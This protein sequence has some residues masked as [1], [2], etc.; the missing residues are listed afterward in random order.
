MYEGQ[1]YLVCIMIF[2]PKLNYSVK[3]ATAIERN[4]LHGHGDQHDHFGF[5]TQFLCAGN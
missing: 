3:K 5:E 1:V 4:K 2:F